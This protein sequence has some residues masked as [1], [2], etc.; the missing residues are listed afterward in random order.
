MARNYIAD[1]IESKENSVLMVPQ[2][3]PLPGRQDQ[4]KNNAGGF[5]FSTGMWAQL[6][7]FLILGSEGG[8]YYVKERQHTLDNIKCVESCLKA[9][10]ERL[11]K[12]VVEISD[13]GRAPK[14]DPAL[15]ALAYAFA[16]GTPSQR[17]SVIAAL[18]KVARIGTHLFHFVDFLDKMHPWGRKARRMISEWYHS[19]DAQNLAHQLVKYQSRDGWSHR[20]VLRLGHVVPK[21]SAYDFLFAYAVGKAQENLGAVDIMEYEDYAAPILAFEKAKTLKPG[22]KGARKELLGLIADYNLPRECVP[23]EWLNDVGVWE[24]LLENMPLT[25]MVRNL[26]KMTSIGLIGDNSDAAIKVVKTLKDAEALRKGRMHPVNLLLSGAT[27]QQGRGTKGSLTWTPVRSVREAL[28]KAF[29]LSFKV[30]KPSGKRFYLGLDVSG[31]MSSQISCAPIS[32][33]DAAVAMALT[34]MNVEDFCDVRMFADA[35]GARSG[36]SWYGRS[37]G[38]PAPLTAAPITAG[39]TIQQC[40]QA[41]RPYNFGGTDC[42]LPMLDAAARKVKVDCFVTYTDNETWAGKIHAPV[43]LEQYRQ[44]MGIDAKFVAVGMVATDY[45]VVDPKDPGSVN[46]VGFDTNTPS[47]ISNFASGV[48]EAEDVDEVDEE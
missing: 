20:D 40:L 28:E 23:T 10:G 16:K 14:N 1:A 27:Y 2:T 6:E 42:A 3:Q 43:A 46:V 38:V 35:P 41:I 19:K 32:C 33:L 12:T 8:T 31:S 5:V 15:F 30:T 13:A 22:D 7:R 39:M 17:D 48:T 18:P 44:K 4:V 11:I 21:S 24:A 47:F 37:N 25:A 29:Y 45:S 9:D 26:A 36:F 34:T